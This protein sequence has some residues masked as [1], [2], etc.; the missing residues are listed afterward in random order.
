VLFGGLG[1]AFLWLS[2]HARA[3]FASVRAL[4]LR[5]GLGGLMVGLLSIAVPEVWGN[6]YSVVAS[7]LTG[8]DTWEWL[9][10]V[11]VTK[12]LA[13]A[14]SSGSGAIGGMFTPSLFVGAAAG[15]VL[16][17]VAA[18]GLPTAWVG[19]PRSLVVI[20][21]SSVLAATTHA[22]LMAITMVLE[23]TDEFQLTVPVM[24]ACAVAYAVST[25]FGAKPLYGNP[26]EA[27]A[28]SA[29]R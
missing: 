5:F 11:L 20:G 7:A 13:T 25:Q 19:D 10:L 1:W 3:A 17:Q 22:P 8:S 9:A 26:I 12:V 2:E 24:L 23:M 21:M 15:G 27:D 29:G 16:S 6:G 4:P 18:L 14:A 28:T